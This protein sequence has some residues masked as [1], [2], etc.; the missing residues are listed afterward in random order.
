MFFSLASLAC[1]PCCASDSNDWRDRSLGGM[2][3]P[4]RHG[5]GLCQEQQVSRWI[6]SDCHSGCGDLVHWLL[7]G[8]LLKQKKDQ[9]PISLMTQ[10]RSLTFPGWL[11]RSVGRTEHFM[12]N[13]METS[14]CPRPEILDRSVRLH[15]KHFVPTR[16]DVNISLIGKM[17]VVSWPPSQPIPNLT[18]VPKRMVWSPVRVSASRWTMGPAWSSRLPPWDSQLSRAKKA[19]GCDSL[20][21]IYQL[22]WSAEG[23]TFFDDWQFINK[24]ENTRCRMVS[25]QKRSLL[26]RCGTCII[27]RCYPS[28]RWTSA[29]LQTSICDASLCAGMATWCG[30]HCGHEVQACAIW[31]WHLASLLDGEQRCPVAKRWA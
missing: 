15:V 1:W 27:C 28:S 14:R 19:A 16:L 25:E 10:F 31:P 8:L 3:I 9:R 29:T 11:R 6:C 7:E 20:H 5:S 17:V 22:A 23:E 2:W 12:W 4:G 30:F 24:S 26:W 18:W 21:D 13:Q